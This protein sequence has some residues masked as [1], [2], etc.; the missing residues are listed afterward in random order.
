MHTVLPLKSCKIITYCCKLLTIKLFH[1]IPKLQKINKKGLQ[2]TGNTEKKT[3][4]TEF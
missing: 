2:G 3:L 4:R 1:I